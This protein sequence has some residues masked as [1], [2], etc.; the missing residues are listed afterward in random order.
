[1]DSLFYV[2]S[3][4]TTGIINTIRY[5]SQIGNRDI[6]VFY[7]VYP[8]ILGNDYERIREKKDWPSFTV[9]NMYKAESAKAIPKQVILGG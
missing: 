5:D 4:C 9:P 2:L 1:M 7:C 8:V 6:P 3:K